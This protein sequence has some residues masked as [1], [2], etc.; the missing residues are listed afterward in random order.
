MT[1]KPYDLKGKELEAYREGFHHGNESNYF[2]CRSGK[3]LAAYDWDTR[4][5]RSTATGRANRGR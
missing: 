2:P 4:T 5:A 3:L 1:K